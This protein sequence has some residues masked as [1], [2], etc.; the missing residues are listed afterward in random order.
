MPFPSECRHGLMELRGNFTV[1]VPTR[2]AGDCRVRGIGKVRI[3]LS[4]PLIFAGALTNQFC[5]MSKSKESVELSP[6]QE[7]LCK[8]LA[9]SP[10]M[11]A[12]FLRA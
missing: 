8:D 10:S 4:A 12:L 6:P 2:I 7:E 11:V 5:N 1:D 9:A 3:E